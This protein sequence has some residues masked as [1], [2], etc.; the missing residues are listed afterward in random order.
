MAEY[1]LTS[2]E[3]DEFQVTAPDDATEMQV[4]EYFQS[5]LPEKEEDGFIERVGERLTERG[6]E[7]DEAIT[8]FQKRVEEEGVSGP[9]LVSLAGNIAGKG[10]AGGALD[11]VGEGLVSAGKA[12][13]Y[14]IPDAIEEPIKEKIVQGYNTLVNTDIGIAASEAIESGYGKWKQFKTENPQVAK[15]IES[16]FNIGLLL[17]PVKTK[18]KASPSVFGKTSDILGQKAAKQIAIDKKKFTESLI[19]PKRTQKVLVEETARTT[20]KGIGPFKRSVVELSAREK[21]IAKEVLK[22]KNVSKKKSIQG[23]LNAVKTENT[24]LAKRLEKDVAKSREI[25]SVDES[26][27]AIDDA[28]SKLIAEN[29]VITGNAETMATKL[30]SKARQLLQENPQ[31]PSGLLK[32][33]KQFDSFVKAQKR[34]A[35]DPELENVLSASVRTVRGAMNDLLDSKVKSTAV[36]RE[37]KRQNLL[38]DAIENIGPKAAE[39]ANYA[40]GRAIQNMAKVLPFRSKFVNEAGTVAGLGIVGASATFAPVFAVG[41]AAGVTA[42][43]GGK[44]LLGSGMKKNLGRVLTGLDKAL[45]TSKNPS[46]IKQLR[47]DRALVVELIK[48]AEEQE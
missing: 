37:L 6:K 16:A 20:E 39:E 42:Y 36:K 34:K 23:N 27:A 28:V 25:I 19:T 29:P 43:Q 26:M 5:N 45:I 18:Q 1:T 46:M 14:V 33:R 11:I 8:S 15:D 35:F 4:M 32:T 40:I 31:T 2:P 24:K 9:A 17:A 12:I 44:L 13:G 41:L 48:N 21:E 30:A 10:I 22:L 47:A 3:G 38:Y 7:V